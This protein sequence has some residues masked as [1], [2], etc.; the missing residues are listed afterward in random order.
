ME[1]LKPFA[2][3]VSNEAVVTDFDRFELRNFLF[4]EDVVFCGAGV[5]M[6]A[7]VAKKSLRFSYS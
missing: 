5:T 2:K 3:A 6:D 7:S 1:R 4:L